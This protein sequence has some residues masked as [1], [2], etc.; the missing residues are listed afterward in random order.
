MDF[1]KIEQK[2]QKKWDKAKIFEANPGNKKKFFFTV[3]YPY[4]SGTLHVGHGRTYTLGDVTARFHKMLGLNVLW[5]IAW[6]IT[7]TPI[8]A[9]SKR[10]ENNEKNV[11]DEHVEYVKLHNPDKA[12]EIVKGFV[13]PEN[14]ANYYSSVMINDMK[15]LGCSIDWRRQF[16]TGEPIYNQFIRWQY[17]HLNSLGYLKRGEHPVF[18][19]PSCGNPVTT[20]DVKSGDQLE[21]TIGEF[22]LL[23]EPFEDGYIIAATLRPE[24]IFGVTN[25][26]VNPDDKYV[27]AKVDGEVWYI[28]EECA[29]K[30]KDQNRNVEVL[31]SFAGSKLIGKEVTIPLADRRVVILP[32]SFV[33]D[34]IATGVVNSVPAHAP[35]DYVALEELKNDAAAIVKFGLDKNYIERI[36]PISLIAVDGF[37]EFPAI[38]VVKKMGIKS[39]KEL[40]QLEKATQEVYNAEF[41]RGVL[42]ETCGD[43]AGIK[44]SDS[45]QMVFDKLQE[46]NLIDKM[47]ESLTKDAYGNFVSDIRC[48]DGTKVVVKVLKDQWFLDYAN[49]GWKEKTKNL[50]AQMEII[51]DAY[52]K[53]FEST[54]AWL[55]EWPC[56]R[57]RGLGTRL[58]YDERWVIESLSD[59]T[60]YM[61][62]YTIVHLIRK[63]KIQQDQLTKEFFDYVFLGK[64][65]AKEVSKIT[66]IPEEI[67]ENMRKEFLYWYPMDERRTAVAHLSNHLTFFLFHHAAIFPENLWPKRI[68]L[69]EL[70][71]AEGKK[72][73]K[74]LGNVI[75]LVFAIRKHGADAV[76]LYLTYAADTN[77]TLDW[78]EKEIET[79]ERRLWRFYEICQKLVRSKAKQ[80]VKSKVGRWLISKFY[81]NLLE[82][83]E[84]LKNYQ[85]K[86]YIQK[87]F[88][89]TLNEIEYYQMRTDGK[90][91]IPKDMVADWILSLSP[92]IPHV[93]EELWHSLGKKS[94]VSIQEWPKVN[95]K[96]ID[97]EVL[98]L[99]DILKRTVEDLNH[100]VELVGK[101][102]KA[103]LY[104]V[105]EKE[106]DYFSEAIKYLEKKIGF[107][108]VAIFMVSDK[109]KYDPQNKASKAKY[110]K[111]GIY[112]E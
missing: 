42:T 66:D 43:L 88:F 24:T 41:Y 59:S 11:I 76:R 58:P 98:E 8:L 2:W 104:V 108:K 100:V 68:S 39:Q 102:D 74:S 86:Q 73:S 34:G 103:Y 80:R 71:I 63:N 12:E 93:C 105:T 94:F 6:H 87:M 26:W 21:M 32:A 111:P 16:T 37:S 107:K 82:A 48:R 47:F 55:R 18:Y 106:F 97:K 23:K 91:I 70:L 5:P 7:G 49:E 25:V 35:Y 31:E 77:S 9:I 13:N 53:S 90:D 57:N 19:C 1:R 101:K 46:K 64:R 67:I 96:K 10:I 85:F 83:T 79:V 15:E 27:K 52:R 65:T 99:E 78:R 33:D 17:Y 112:L 30:L 92:V 60:I 38:D 14:V 4:T 54:I 110:G 44:V 61:A 62:F 109:K 45:K 40:T 29:Q 50:L 51:P 56:A 20:D 69:N 36:K 95:E 72:M 3:P 75:P 22:Y 89:E 81:Q 84:S 28:S